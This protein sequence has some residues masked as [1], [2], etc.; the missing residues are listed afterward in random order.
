MSSVTSAK[1]ASPRNVVLCQTT[2]GKYGAS[3][4][5]VT[6]PAWYPSAAY[7]DPANS[8]ATAVLVSSHRASVRKRVDERCVRAARSSLR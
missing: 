2:V 5:T 6:K 8:K 3:P 4:L 7:S 1:R